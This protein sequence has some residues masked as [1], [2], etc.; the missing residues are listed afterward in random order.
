[1][2]FAP[3]AKNPAQVYRRLLQNIAHNLAIARNTSALIDVLNIGLYNERMANDT[4]QTLIAIEMVDPKR[5][6]NRSEGALY[7]ALSALILA[8]I[9]IGN[10]L[11]AH[12]QIPRYLV[13][14]PLYA[15][16]AVVCLY[17]YRRHYISFRYTLTDQTFAIERIAGN[18]ERALAAVR[19][20]DIASIAAYAHSEKKEATIQNASVK[21]KQNAL[22]LL[23][24][25]DGEETALL[26]SPSE[27]FLSKLTAQ[28]E[29]AVREERV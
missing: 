14:L 7:L 11:F 9:S 8:V 24:R 29:T 4:I 2:N 19:L 22:L 25:S 28:W 3:L 23:A 17:I 1:M 26:I 18:K 16:I 5:K 21:P 12:A 13:H 15:M 6:L 20:A 10:L 27:D